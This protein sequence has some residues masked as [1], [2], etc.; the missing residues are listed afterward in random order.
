MQR[1]RDDIKHPTGSHPLELEILKRR[2]EKELRWHLG[3]PEPEDLTLKLWIEMF[4][5]ERAKAVCKDKL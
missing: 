1:D 2:W 4:E 3:N 5:E